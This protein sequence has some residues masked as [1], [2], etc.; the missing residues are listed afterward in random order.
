MRN[1]ELWYAFL[2]KL[3]LGNKTMTSFNYNATIESIF[4]TLHSSLFI[5]KSKG[6]L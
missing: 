4:F 5:K 6:F 2:Q 1:E 3:L